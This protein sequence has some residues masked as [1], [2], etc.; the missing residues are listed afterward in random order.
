MNSSFSIKNLPLRFKL[1]GVYS[2]IFFF[3]SAIGLSAIWFYTWG[4]IKAEMENELQ[5][6][7]DAIWN[8]VTTT[9]DA[10]IR[11]HLRAVAKTNLEMVEEIYAKYQ[12][13][14]ISEA[15]GRAL[16]ADLLLSQTIGTTGYVYTLDSEGTVTVHPKP[17][18]V[19]VNLSQHA[20]VKEQMSLKEGY[21]EYAWQNPGDE[22]KR[23][24]TLYMT[25]FEPWD[26][27]IS[28]SSYKTEFL[29]LVHVEEFSANVLDIRIGET[30][31]PYLIDTKGNLIIHPTLQG[32]NISQEKDATGRMFMQEML[33][34]KN[35][36]IVYDWK[37]PGEKKYRKKLV[38]FRHVP[39]FDW[40]VAS[41]AYYDDFMGLL[42]R[43]GYIIIIVSV[44]AVILMIPLTLM[45]NSRILR[46]LNIVGQTAR[47]L[48]K[49]DLTVEVETGTRDE[50]GYLLAAMKT[51]VENLREIITRTTEVANQVNDAVADISGALAEQSATASQQS[52]SVSQISSTMEEF[53]ASSAQI[54]ENANSVVNISDNALKSSQQGV[55]SVSDMMTKMEVIN[56]DNQNNIK[57]IMA[58]RKKAEEITKIMELINNIAD[59]TRLI[60]FNAA[61]EASGAGE[62]GKRFSVVAVEIRRLADN[63][64][65]STGDI[66]NKI[67]EIQEAA[68]GMVISSEKS[69][70]GIQDALVSF[71]QTTDLLNEILCG[72][73]ETTDAA[74]Q[75]SLSTQQQKTA[76][77]QIV[78]ALRD[79]ADGS[80]QT[81]RSINQISEV[82]TSLGA[83]SDDLQALM[84]RFK[85]K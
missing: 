39:E 8:L 42:Y 28:A 37:N 46:R 38:V 7:T 57:E 51:M 45:L 3:V 14:L 73:Q 47:R 9:A 52:A 32:K 84:A 56:D 44:I 82:S 26:W 61:I 24:K 30:G 1:L 48:S 49:C 83:L 5:N 4:T 19:G 59:Q 29:Q 16:A 66:E 80:E 31:Y 60:A 78:T 58:L 35:G 54:A 67:N 65:E 11:N 34:Q 53:S 64:T 6:T 69:T 55:R 12:A 13:G 20:F 81:S 79:I 50:I 71:G 85:L 43:I 18:L 22:T 74:K 72:S 2:L 21:L 63:V 40:I 23:P 70:K 25:Y 62:A 77:Q 41:T 36:I 68:N 17:S 75:I 10:S 33:E 27:I 76:T 15:D